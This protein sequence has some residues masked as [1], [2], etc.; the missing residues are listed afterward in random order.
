MSFIFKCGAYA[1]N[2]MLFGLCNT[3]ATFQK[4]VMQTFL[5]Y[6]ND[7][8]QVF[9]DYFNVYGQKEEHLNHF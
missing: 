7:F 1:Y 5:K 9:L 4:V 6:L 2:I 8:M 3:L